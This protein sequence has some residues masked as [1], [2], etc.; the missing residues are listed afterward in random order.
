MRYRNKF[1]IIVVLILQSAYTQFNAVGY[2]FNA[3]VQSLSLNPGSY[4]QYSEQ[5]GIPLT[6]NIQFFAG[7]S[8]LAV[9]DL[10]AKNNVSFN[11]KVSKTISKLSNDDFIQTN[12]RQDLFTYGFKDDLQRFKSMG[13]YWEIDHITYLPADFLQLGLDGNASHMNDVYTLGSLAT[14]TEFVQTFHYGVNQMINAKLTFGYRLKLYS[15]II[16][17]QSVRNKGKF[18]TTTGQN[19]YY[20]HHLD[21]VNLSIQTSGFADLADRK[22]LNSKDVIN[23]YLTKFIFSGNYGPGVDL[24]ITYKYD[25]RTYFTASLLDLGF[26]YF[27]SDARSDQIKGDY[28]FEGASIQFPKSGLIDYWKDIRIDF[29]NEVPKVSKKSSYLSLRPASLYTSVKYGL[30]DLKK[31][32]CE[33]FLNL[34]DEYTEYVGLILFSQYRPVKIH[35]GASVFY[36][37][38]WSKHFSTR[39]NFTVDNLSYTSLGAGFT[40]NVGAVQL[41][42]LADN[43]LGLIDLSSSHKQSVQFGLNLVR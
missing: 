9:S 40:L 17:I 35:T 24:G 8:G 26:I 43:L 41:Y 42:M 39:A 11:D 14:K 10:F 38:N 28:V 31:Q 19:N 33:N 27:A 15:G 21:D 7:S 5:F 1:L 12:Y 22:N 13:L 16:N 37:K 18:Y 4:F 20:A 2:D 32:D 25:Y 36:E 6:S 34:K 30:G 29:E 23:H 3:N